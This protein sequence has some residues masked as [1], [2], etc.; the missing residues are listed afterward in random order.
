MK[1]ETTLDERPG[2]LHAVPLFDLLAL[3]GMLLL[4]GP[5]FL[6]RSGVMVELPVSKFEMQRYGESIVVT[7]GPEHEGVAP[8]YLGRNRVDLAGLEEKLTRAAEV[9]EGGQI[10]AILKTDENTSVKTERKVSEVILKAGLRLA[11]AGRK[12]RSGDNEA[13][14]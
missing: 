9:R 6:G 10:L 14:Q 1:L 8:V 4:L 13:N 7:I 11:L 5:M 2:F 3:G 12:E